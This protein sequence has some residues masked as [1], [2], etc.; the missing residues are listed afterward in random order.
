M[1]VLLRS[2]RGNCYTLI[3]HTTENCNL[4]QGICKFLSIPLF[5]ISRVLNCTRTT[6]FNVKICCIVFFFCFLFLMSLHIILQVYKCV[7]FDDDI[8]AVKIVKME[9][10]YTETQEVR[11]RMFSSKPI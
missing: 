6:E 1:A 3:L 9:P 11:L 8:F 2:V 10:Q 7:T 4:I 5:K